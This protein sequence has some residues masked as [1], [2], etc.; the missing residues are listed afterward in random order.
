[1]VMTQ[2]LIKQTHLVCNSSTSK[3]GQRNQILSYHIFYPGFAEITDSISLIPDDWDFMYSVVD[4][5]RRPK[6]AM[7]LP[8]GGISN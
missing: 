6:G 7:A 3:W 2:I 5:R 4:L 8:D 1:M